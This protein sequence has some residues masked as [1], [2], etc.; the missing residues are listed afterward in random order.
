MTIQELSESERAE[1][2]DSLQWI[3][4]SAERLDD[5]EITELGAVWLGLTEVCPNGTVMA[6]GVDPDADRS[7]GYLKRR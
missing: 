5:C 1:V 7:T 4:E 3:G 2:I 6:E